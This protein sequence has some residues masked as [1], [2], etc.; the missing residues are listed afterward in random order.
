[1]TPGQLAS[2]MLLLLSNNQ[3][4]AVVNVDDVN[5]RILVERIGGAQMIM[6]STSSEWRDVQPP[7]ALLIAREVENKV[8]YGL[9]SEGTETCVTSLPFSGEVKEEREATALCL[10]AGIFLG[11]PHVNMAQYFEKTQ[12]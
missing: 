1:M 12:T 5:G 3:G 4:R 9:R 8:V 7:H 2:A 10:A 11:L 6:T